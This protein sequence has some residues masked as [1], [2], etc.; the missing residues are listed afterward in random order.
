MKPETTERLFGFQH[1]FDHPATLG[2]T[3]IIAAVLLIAP[4]VY[5][6]LGR[7][8]KIAPHEQTELWRRYRSWL[9][10][11]PIL[12]APILLG[13]FWT[14]LGVAILSLLCYREYAR[15]TG[16][17]REKVISLVVTLG[18]LLVTFAV[19]DH[20]YGL[21]VAAPAF[22]VGFIASAAILR[23]EPKGYIQRVALGVF[24][25]SLFGTCLAHLGYF[26]NDDNYRPYLILIVLSVEMN[27]VFV[28]VIGKAVGR[29]LLAPNTSPRRTVAGAV[30][31]ILLTTPFFV[32]LG[33]WVFQGTPLDKLLPLIALGV[34]ISIAG[35]LGA[36]MLSSIKRDLE[37][38]DMG[39]AIPGHG[40][41]LDRFDSLILVAP[42][43]FHYIHHFVGIGMEPTPHRIL[44]GP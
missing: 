34:I 21:F 2:M 14:I 41:L 9:G 23:D 39:V 38:K 31:G 1:A 37:I 4:L 22:T 25:F 18:I 16:L 30:G 8:G 19:L 3:L 28:Y 6:L 29:R 7:A 24:G 11:A 36:L 44:T 20:W 33:F 40:G 43:A 12:L 17:F 27:D 42:L 26:A 10:I 13:A 15:A 32:L 5:W 35:Q